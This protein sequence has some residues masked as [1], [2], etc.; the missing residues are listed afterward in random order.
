[1]DADR[2]LESLLEG[3]LRIAQGSGGLGG[4]CLGRGDAVEQPGQDGETEN[5][6][7]QRQQ[8]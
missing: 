2:L 3:L 1:M 7:D 6:A 5:Q 8:E 4:R